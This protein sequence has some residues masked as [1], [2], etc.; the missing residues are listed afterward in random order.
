[1]E[2]H[3]RSFDGL[4]AK[5]FFVK[6]KESIEKLKEQMNRTEKRYIE[7][8]GA[9]TAI[10]TFLFTCVNLF[11]SKTEMTAKD[12]LK[13]TAVF[14]IILLLFVNAIFF[15]STPKHELL[16]HPRSYILLGCTVAYVVILRDLLLRLVGW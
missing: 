11:S 8:I 2:K 7:I 4:T 1:M 13:N 12:M 5:A 9:F 16:K 3:K 14:G 6:E 15:I 10:I